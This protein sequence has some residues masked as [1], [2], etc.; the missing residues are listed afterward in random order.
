MSNSVVIFGA[1]GRF[2]RAAQTAFLDAGWHVRGLARSWDD[3]PGDPRMEAVTGKAH[4]AEDLIHAARGAD[5]IVNALNPPYPRWRHDLPV[6]TRNVIAAARA[7]GATVMIP[8]N[9]YVYGAGMPVL[10]TEATP[11]RPTERKGRLREEMERA[12][13]AAAAEGVRSIILRAG[14]FIER[15]KSGNWF[16]S[17]ITRD[18]A[19]GRMLYPGPLDRV[20][21]WAYLPDMAR[22]AVALAERRAELAPFAELGF[23]GYSLTGR[24]LADLLGRITGRDL[25]ITTLSWP[26]LRVL[27]LVWPM[28][29]EVAEMRY[30]W[31]VPH[32]IDGARLAATLPD[33][34]PTPVA[35]ALA[36]AVGQRER[37]PAGHGAPRPAAGPPLLSD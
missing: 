29:R 34:R 15:E 21:A 22:A 6:L 13:A 30:L 27:G 37:S 4:A 17:Q 24:E 18:L 10:L 5:V 26:L 11:H 36:E 9:V 35:A 8:G 12:Y 31:Q 32:A 28:M 3:A 14:D 16:D 2:G 19:K 20:H 23:P 33:F 1:K 25:R 7:S